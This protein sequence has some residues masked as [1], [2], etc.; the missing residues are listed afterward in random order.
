MTHKHKTILVTGRGEFPFDMLRYD[1]AWFSSQEDVAKATT[2][3]DIRAVIL[4]AHDM[5]IARWESFNWTVR[6]M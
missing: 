2:G 3:R 6:E 4:E 1:S 5:T